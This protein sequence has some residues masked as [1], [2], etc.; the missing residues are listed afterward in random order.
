MKKTFATV[1]GL[2]TLLASVGV[3]SAAV[4]SNDFESYA[5]NKT[6][7]NNE[8][9][10]VWSSYVDGGATL[11]V[12]SNPVAGQTGQCLQMLD[13]S[14]NAASGWLPQWEAKTTAVTTGFHINFD[15]NM[16]QFV[17]A[18]NKAL[19][20]EIRKDNYQS[21]AARI[22]IGVNGDIKVNGVALGIT[23]QA[24]EWGHV[25]LV[26]DPVSQGSAARW[27]IEFT[28][29]ETSATQTGLTLLSNSLASVNDFTFQLGGT[30]TA[31]Q[32]GDGVAVYL[33]NIV[34]DTIPEPSALGILTFFG[35]AA[36]LRRTYNGR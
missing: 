10:G 26:F 27:S 28:Q 20:L 36:F 23:I 8:W 30:G 7:T 2:A 9:S 4:A 35:G 31:T 18:D 21:V 16:S 32:A 12:V 22:L 1:L 24:N 5:L 19:V 29:G 33:D 25:K 14:T 13:P 6:F 3:C 15:F 11:K 34:I 17:D